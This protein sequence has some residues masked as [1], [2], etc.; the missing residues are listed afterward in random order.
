MNQQ[1][2][3]SSGLVRDVEMEQT[4]VRLITNTGSIVDEA[5]ATSMPEAINSI[6][7]HQQKYHK[8][9]LLTNFLK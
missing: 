9:I 3:A 2:H 5:N 1:T 8:E 4:L 7:L 6:H